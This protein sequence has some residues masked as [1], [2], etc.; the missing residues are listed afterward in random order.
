MY[1]TEVIVLDASS[2]QGG[3]ILAIIPSPQCWT[4]GGGLLLNQFSN[5][6]FAALSS[7]SFPRL[8]FGD[9]VIVVS[10]YEYLTISRD[11][12][13]DAAGSKVTPRSI[14]TPRI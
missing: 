13:M 14:T 2:S 8:W 1:F 10:R 7:V 6:Y 11:V 5:V 9:I 3:G 12:V 4:E